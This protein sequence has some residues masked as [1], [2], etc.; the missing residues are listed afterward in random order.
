M[1][2]PS[3]SQ[4]VATTTKAR[5]NWKLKIIQ[6]T[7]LRNLVLNNVSIVVVERLFAQEGWV[8]KF[9]LSCLQ[10]AEGSENKTQN[11]EILCRD[12]PNTVAESLPVDLFAC[13]YC[14]TGDCIKLHCAWY[15]KMGSRARNKRQSRANLF[16]RVLSPLNPWFW[17]GASIERKG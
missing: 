17:D 11:C 2:P 4:P 6:Q 15:V 1:K 3:P 8:L 5:Y 7:Q 10:C 16:T 9:R 14:C 13:S 12:A